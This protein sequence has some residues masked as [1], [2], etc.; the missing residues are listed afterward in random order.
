[1]A[2][3]LNL[4]NWPEFINI[5]S[6]ETICFFSSDR[7][8]Y[9]LKGNSKDSL[10]T[11]NRK[12]L[13]EGLNINYRD[14]VCLKQIHGCGIY[15]ATT[16]DKGRGAVDYNTA[17]EGFDAIITIDK[18]V[19]V[20]VL[21]ADC[22]SIFFYDTAT[23]GAGIAHAGW[24][25]TKKKIVKKLILKMKENYSTNVK[26]LV[27]GFGPSIKSC[28]YEV[29]QEL[30][31]NFAKE[32]IMKKDNRLYLDLVKENMIQLIDCGVSHTN[33]FDSGICTACNPERFYSYR[34]GGLACG[35]NISI[36]MLKNKA[37]KCY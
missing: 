28:C 12:R 24:R 9:Q 21:T 4:K 27:V 33:I 26:N 16:K 29:R 30:V 1:M 35:R 25:S 31:N 32:S 5:V 7:T 22:L 8:D 23:S 37:A 36:V 11:E 15:V 6:K 18:A 19:P 13:C 20:C 14:L 3:D 2:A 17:I 10:I 34:I